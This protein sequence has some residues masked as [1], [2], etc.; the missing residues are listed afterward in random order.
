[1]CIFFPLQP[2]KIEAIF[3]LGRKREKDNF[4]PFYSLGVAIRYLSRCYDSSPRLLRM[5]ITRSR[6]DPSVTLRGIDTPSY[7]LAGGFCRK[8]LL[9]VRVPAFEAAARVQQDLSR[10]LVSRSH[11]REYRLS[12]GSTGDRIRASLDSAA[13]CTLHPR[14]TLHWN[15]PDTMRIILLIKA[16][17]F[18]ESNDGDSCCSFGA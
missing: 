12:Y 18:A 8:W 9:L 3:N 11:C 15:S 6:C 1:M 13:K 2:Y 7:R 17:P 5:L 10:I 14:V 4:N 16:N